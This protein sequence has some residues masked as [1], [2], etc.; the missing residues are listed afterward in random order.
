[1]HELRQKDPTARL[2]PLD[3]GPRTINKC[4]GILTS[5][6]FYASGHSLAQKNVAQRIDKLLAADLEEEG[7]DSVIEENILTPGR[8]LPPSCRRP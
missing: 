1:M 2:K 5:I 3:P 4:L 7:E 6:G 8:K